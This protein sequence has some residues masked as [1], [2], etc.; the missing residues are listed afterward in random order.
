[1][2][3]LTVDQYQE[4]KHVQFT[5][6][7]IQVGTKLFTIYKNKGYAEGSKVYGPVFD[8]Y[9]PGLVDT[10]KTKAQVVS[11]IKDQA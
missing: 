5:H 1:M 8:I 6:Q 4:I 11:F 3:R 2:A 7:L 10:V 9:G